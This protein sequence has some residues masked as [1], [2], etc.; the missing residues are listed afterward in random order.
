MK[1]ND[2]SGEATVIILV[3]HPQRVTVDSIVYE[4]MQ[5]KLSVAEGE[6]I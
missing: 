1:N 2:G 5:I 3:V 4:D 6:N